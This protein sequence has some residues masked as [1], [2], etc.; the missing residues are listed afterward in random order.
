MVETTS[1]LKEEKTELVKLCPGSTQ[2]L[3]AE[4]VIWTMVCLILEWQS[5]LL[6]VKHHLKSNIKYQLYHQDAFDFKWQKHN[7]NLASSKNED[8]LAFKA[9][10]YMRVGRPQRRKRK[11]SVDNTAFP[12]F[13][14]LS[15]SAWLHSA[16]RLSP[17]GKKYRFWQPQIYF[18]LA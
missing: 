15:V 7:S 13:S 1:S 16:K 6:R 5:L 2:L 12:S 18:L 8:L 11:F 4:V 9:R 17:L 3:A 14:S 10:K